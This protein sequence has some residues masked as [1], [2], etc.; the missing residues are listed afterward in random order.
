MSS[1][2]SK[3]GLLTAGIETVVFNGWQNNLRLC[4]GTV[5]LIVT[6]EVGPRILVYRKCG[7]INPLK[8]F[9]NQSGTAGEPTWRN[10]GGHR[11]WIAP[12]DK[13][14]TYF[15]DNAPVAWERLGA[16]HARLRPLPETTNGL[17]KELDISLDPVGTGVTIVHRVTRLEPSPA[18]LAPWALTVMAPGGIAVVPHPEMGKH[19]QDLLPNRSLVLWP[20]TDMRD[21]RWCFGRKYLLLRQDPAGAPTKIG[22]A[23]QLGWSGYLLGG[24]F[25]LKRYPWNPSAA[26]P[27]MGCNFEVFSNGKMVELES[28]G[29]LTLLHHCQTVAHIEEWELHDTGKLS[30]SS[31]SEEQI[32][33]LIRSIHGP[34]SA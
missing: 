30:D 14:K 6:L 16:L 5:E 10:R 25:F 24:V 34:S 1:V 33:E 3:E 12:E 2:V 18:R 15:P 19:P 21:P 8:I 17:Q 20:Y 7:G 4:N 26:Y 22:L 11:L 29:P 9:E 31:A 32:D 23:H 27:D 28:L 13:V